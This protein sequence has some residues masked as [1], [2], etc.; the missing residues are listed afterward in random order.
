MD[1]KG[2]KRGQVTIFILLGLVILFIF[3]FL[4]QLTT[5]QKKEALKMEQ[6]DTFT[7]IF[8]KEAL[9][10]YVEDCLSDELEKGLVLLGRQG[11]IWAGQPGGTVEFVEG[12]NGITYQAGSGERIA[13]AITAED[14]TPAD[15]YPCDGQNL[16]EPFC[17]YQYPNTAVGFG[18]LQLKTKAALE[19]ELKRYLT[20]RTV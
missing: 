15:A 18:D 11:K 20:N 2:A 13:Y 14:S 1:K 8:K 9:R 12:R 5:T 19:R 16:P 17:K 10:I 6:E 4:I 3:L 7:K